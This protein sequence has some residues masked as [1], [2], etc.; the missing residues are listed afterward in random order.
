MEFSIKHGTPEKARSA[1][2]VITVSQSRKLSNH[3]QQVDKASKGQ[4]S[5]IL[6]SGDMD[7]EIGQTLMLHQVTGSACARILLVGVGKD[8]ERNEHSYNR[9]V[10]SIASTL[11]NSGA[12][13]AEIY[14]DDINLK[15]R[16]LEWKSRQLALLMANSEYRFDRLKS[17]GKKT[18]KGLRR[19]NINVPRSE[20]R[21]VK[22]AI[23]EASALNQ[24]MNL[25]RDLGNLPGN[26]CTPTYL[27]KQ[28][29]ELGKTYRQLRV[30]VLEETDMRKLKMGSLLS[31][32]AGSRQPA[33]QV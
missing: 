30:K 3:G 20:A 11:A 24:G 12:K 6:K 33:K 25:A 14:P 16:S 32:S 22:Q 9:I 10:Q 23:E 15:G 1:C 13:D 7:G 18:R 5:A 29:R 4:L 8:S 26:V 19:L 17:G 31:V 21:A 28:A 2:Q 27:A